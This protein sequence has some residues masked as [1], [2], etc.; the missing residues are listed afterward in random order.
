[1]ARAR[2]VIEIK[3]RIPRQSR[4]EETLAA[5]L[6]G[7][8]QVLEAG[9]LATFTTNAVAERAG[10][11]IGTLYQYFA[12]KNALVTM[13]AKRELQATLANVAKAMSD[14]RDAAAEQRVRDVVR[15]IV[16]AF[17]GRQRARKAVIQAV[18][19]QAG[20]VA[21][22]APVAAFIAAHSLAMLSREQTFVLS[23]ALI[24]TIRS[25]VLEEQPFL[26]SR[27]FEDE[28]VRLVLCYLGAVNAPPA[29]TAPA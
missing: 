17:H 29:S 25:A 10:V 26:K 4:S 7:A 21:F 20:G 23:R 24:G 8:A 22:H 5:I 13:L 14:D 6:E 3:R 9:G 19:S 16:N 1:L 28:L 18:L 2:Q 15:A 27:S 11:S 12:D